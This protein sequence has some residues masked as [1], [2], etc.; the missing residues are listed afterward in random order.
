MGSVGCTPAL[1]GR[2]LGPPSDPGRCRP[3]TPGAGSASRQGVRLWV[4]G[5]NHCVRTCQRVE[6]AQVTSYTNECVEGHPPCPLP[7]PSHLAGYQPR[8][9]R[10]KGNL[11]FYFKVTEAGSCDREAGPK[12]VVV[13]VNCVVEKNPTADLPHAFTLSMC[14]KGGRAG[15]GGVNLVCASR[16]PAV[17][18]LSQNL[19]GKVLVCTCLPL[20]PKRMLMAGWRL[21]K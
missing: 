4:L 8:W 20:R 18:P 7:A 9:L 17:L 10:L 16:C 5:Y 11:L 12:G 19:Q 2:G 1:V 3:V 14:H 21:S 13:L 6:H 15:Q